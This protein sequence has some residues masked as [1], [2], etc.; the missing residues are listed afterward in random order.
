LDLLGKDAAWKSEPT[1]VLPNGDWL[2]GGD[3]L[4]D[5]IPKKS[6]LK[7]NKPKLLLCFFSNPKTIQ[8]VFPP[9][10]VSLEQ[11]WKCDESDLKEKEKKHQWFSAMKPMAGSLVFGVSSLTSN[12]RHLARNLYLPKTHLQRPQKVLKTRFF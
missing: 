3:L 1:H 6:A 5:R 4:W 9:P 12:K 8:N 7:N 2:H 11:Q 10:S